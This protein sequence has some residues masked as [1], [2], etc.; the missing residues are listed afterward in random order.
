LDKL[1][2]GQKNSTYVEK[3]TNIVICKTKFKNKQT[4]I[5][6]MYEETTLEKLEELNNKLVRVEKKLD[7]LIPRLINTK[8][9]PLTEIQRNVLEMKRS[10][11]KSCQIAKTLNISESYVSQI[12]K[13]LRKKGFDYEN[14]V[15]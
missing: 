11:L 5:S 4:F 15:V 6:F 13:V 1:D 9:R 7:F 10:G 12:L 3:T 8:P 2:I 14:N